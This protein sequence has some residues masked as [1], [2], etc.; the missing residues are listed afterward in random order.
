MGD[1]H[2][3]RFHQNISTV[4]KRYQGKWSPSMLADYRWT[5]E[6]IHCYFLGHIYIYIYIYICVCVCVFMCTLCNIK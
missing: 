6:V 2:G 3:Q 5:Q 1:E 4:V